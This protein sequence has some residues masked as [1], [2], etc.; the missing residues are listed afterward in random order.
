MKKVFFS[1]MLLFYSASLYS[2]LILKNL[3]L[4][5]PGKDVLYIGV[6]NELKLEGVS[7]KKNIE[8]VVEERVFEE[9]GGVFQAVVFKPGIAK[10]DVCRK[11]KTGRQLLLSKVFRAETLAVPTTRISGATDSFL[12]VAAILINPQIEVFYPG[13]RFKSDI[14]VLSFSLVITDSN[15]EIVLEETGTPGNRFSEA[16]IG[17]IKTCKSGDKLLFGGIRAVVQSGRIMKMPP[18]AVYVK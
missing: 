1:A 4:T 14:S 11:A 16:M 13:S 12:S 10:V 7:D 15:G 17:K 5:E 8:I 18:F 3:S 9:I 2:Q 6:T